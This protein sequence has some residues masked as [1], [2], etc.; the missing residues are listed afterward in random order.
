MAPLPAESTARFKVFYTVG[1]RQHVQEVRT[2]PASPAAFSDELTAYYSALGDSIYA[3]VIDDIQFAADN[4]VIFNSVAAPIVGQA[5]GSGAPSVEGEDAYYFSFIGRSSGGR[6]VR[7]FQF[8]AKALG[9]DYR[10]PAG[11]NIELDDARNVIADSSENWLAIDGLTA[12]WKTYINAGVNAYW[13]RKVR[14]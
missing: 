10:F 4:S 6:R 14:P 9:G 12:L 7:F 13:Q 11:E 5:F 3:T 2:S 8:G 1:G